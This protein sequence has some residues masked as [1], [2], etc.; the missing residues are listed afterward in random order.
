MVGGRSL[1]HLKYLHEQQLSINTLMNFRLLSWVSDPRQNVPKYPELGNFPLVFIVYNLVT[2]NAGN[3]VE[4]KRVLLS[5]KSYKCLD[6][7]EF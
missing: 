6:V 1:H 2:S 5:G 3:L 4:G 7:R